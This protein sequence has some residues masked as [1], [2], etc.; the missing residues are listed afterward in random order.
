[1]VE[2]RWC[3]GVSDY[4]LI[5]FDCDGTL[6]DSHYLN[7]WAIA[8]LLN[9]NG[10][11]HYTHESV[12]ARFLGKKVSDIFSIVSEEESIDLPQDLGAQ[13]VNLVSENVEHQVKIIDGAL[14]MVSKLSGDYLLG[15][16]S[17]AQIDIVLKSLK[18]TDLSSYF[19]KESVF[20]GSNIGNPKPAP[21]VYIRVANFFDIDPA[22]CLVIEDSP[23]GVQAGVAAGMEVWGFTGVSHDPVDQEKMLLKVG[24]SC[25]FPR[26]IHICQKLGY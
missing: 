23:T 16:A 1:M 21:D 9:R 2:W 10:T 7:H 15:V 6:V 19:S 14:E 18:V 12:E 8:E 3:N 17:N 26:L 11:S 25:V 20:S 13:F 24:A 5:I 22:R 4:D